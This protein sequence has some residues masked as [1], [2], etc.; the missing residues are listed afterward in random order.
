MGIIS[1]KGRDDG[2]RRGS[3]E[4]FL[5]TDAPINR[6]N[7]GGAL[8]TP[9]GE[10]VGINSQIMSPSGGNI[11]IGFAIPSN[12]ATGV[13]SQLVST[14]HV[15]RARLGVSVQ[16]VTSDLAKSLGLRSV[17]GAIVDDVTAGGPAAKAGIEQGDVIL[18]V[19]GHPVQDSNGLRNQVSAMAPGSTVAVTVFRHGSERALTVSLD[20]MPS[21]KLAANGPVSSAGELGMTLQPLTPDLARSLNVPAGTTGV[22]VTDVDESG[23][24]AR[25]DIRPGDVLSAIDGH[26]VRT[27]DEVRAALS[28]HHT[29]PAL[30]AVERAGRKLF[31]ALPTVG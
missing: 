16:G 1:A 26:P 4:D 31:V 23:T 6:G 20:Q 22:A 29:R 15:S 19:N 17:H 30:V 24:A 3:Y 12:M 11:G 21:D 9:R 5:Q 2:C 18:S 28:G 7:S 25:A 14:G 8:V 10:L 27:V 13:M